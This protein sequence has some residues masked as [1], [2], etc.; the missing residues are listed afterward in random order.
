MH[1]LNGLVAA[2]TTPFVKHAE[3][4]ATP[5]ATIPAR[6]LH[7]AAPVAANHCPVVGGAALAAGV[8][9][10]CLMGHSYL[11]TVIKVVFAFLKKLMPRLKPCTELCKP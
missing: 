3:L 9:G 7:G 11:Y 6:R 2:A 8:R 10:A 5:R 4:Q 1:R